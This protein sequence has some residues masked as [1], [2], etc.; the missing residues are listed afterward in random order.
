[1]K[2]ADVPPDERARR[3]ERWQEQNRG[4]WLDKVISLMKA[5]GI[6]WGSAMERVRQ[7]EAQQ[8]G[9]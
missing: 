6:G 5:E 8:G 3:W 1:V 9:D 4:T 7:Q 2:W